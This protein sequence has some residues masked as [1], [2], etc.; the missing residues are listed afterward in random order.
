MPPLWRLF[1]ALL[2]LTVAGKYYLY[3]THGG[4]PHGHGTSDVQLEMLGAF[5]AGGEKGTPGEEGGSNF[6]NDVAV[7]EPLERSNNIRKQNPWPRIQAAVGEDH[8]GSSMNWHQVGPAI[9]WQASTYQRRRGHARQTEAGAGGDVFGG[10]SSRQDA[11]RAEVQPS[12]FRPWHQHQYHRQEEQK[13]P[14]ARD[15]ADAVKDRPYRQ[16]VSKTK[17]ESRKRHQLPILS[18]QQISWRAQQESG[19]GLLPLISPLLSPT[20]PFPSLFSSPL[21]LFMNP[22]L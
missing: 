10:G 11:R 1:T 17:G 18:T 5:I 2:L 12:E 22:F 6:H 21:L 14:V 9:S 8:I 20:L 16:V 13:Q 19:N 7:A 4:E 15:A 3:L